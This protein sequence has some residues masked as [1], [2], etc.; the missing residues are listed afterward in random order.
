[1]NDVKEII[2][3]TCPKGCEARVWMEEG[4]IKI[5]G[6]ICKKGKEYLEQEFRGP[7][8]VLTSTVIVLNSRIKRLPVR[9]SK[10]IPK[11]DQLRA[12]EQLARVKVRPP[13]RIGE[14]IIA[15]LLSTDVDVISCDDLRS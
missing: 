1:M 2:C 8:R 4:A 5:K 15:N 11:K 7:R 6:K 9:T 12:M 13:V 14:V 10:G 3:I